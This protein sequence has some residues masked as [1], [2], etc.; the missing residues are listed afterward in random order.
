[1]N[2]LVALAAERDQIFLTVA[3]RVAP[4]LHVMDVELIG[5]AT[6]LASPSVSSQDL[7]AKCFV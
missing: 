1:V 4:K 3:P 5:T 2:E 6:I 7:Q